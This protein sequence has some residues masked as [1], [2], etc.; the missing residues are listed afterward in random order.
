M[1][2][3]VASYI[4]HWKLLLNT[5]FSDKCIINIKR[6]NT[7]FWTITKP[8]M[9]HKDSSANTNISPLENDVVINDQ[10]AVASVLNDIFSQYLTS[11]IVVCGRHG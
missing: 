8:F 2:W 6:N 1:L 9:F 7:E 10:T 11:C 5:Y 4:Y 3:I